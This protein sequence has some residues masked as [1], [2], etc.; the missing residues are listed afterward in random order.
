MT[1]SLLLGTAALVL[2]AAPVVAQVPTA[3]D[4]AATV[5]PA[6]GGP[7][8][9]AGGDFADIVVTAQKRTERAVNVPITITAYTGK[10]L[11]EIGVT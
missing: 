2:I 1:R 6:G 5:G 10:T 7:L 8:A 3:A 11:R 9:D 4:P